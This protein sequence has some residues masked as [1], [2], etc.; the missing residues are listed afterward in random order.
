[1]ETSVVNSNQKQGTLLVSIS[2]ALVIVAILCFALHFLPK[3]F[4]YALA[5]FAKHHYFMAGFVNLAI[6]AV[7]FKFYVD[8]SP[9]RHRVRGLSKKRILYRLMKRRRLRRLYR[10][11]HQQARLR[12][13]QS[14]SRFVEKSKLAG[15]RFVA[16]E[17]LKSEAAREQ[18]LH[19]LRTALHKGNHKD[20]KVVLCFFDG[21]QRKHTLARVIYLD[22]VQVGLDSGAVIPLSNI[23]AVEL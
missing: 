3:T 5:D 9:A 14:E 17:C 23:Y 12:A 1:M 19:R 18:R 22:H 15:I 21:I 8:Q 20:H 13:H 2:T 7:V 11:L 10:H 4:F 6:A 16:L